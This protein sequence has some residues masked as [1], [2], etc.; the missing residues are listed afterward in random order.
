M[1]SRVITGGET[2]TYAVAE[3][4]TGDTLSALNSAKLEAQS[5]GAAAIS[6]SDL[7]SGL[8]GQENS[9]AERV[10]C[11][12]ANAFYLRWL[13]GLP[14]LP[15]EQAAA[16]DIQPDWHLA[17]PPEMQP[18]A[19]R[20][21]AFAV[22]EADHD[23][24]YWIDSDHLLRGLLSFPN[25]ADFALLKTELS[26][27]VA[28]ERSRRDREDFLPDQNPNLKVVE[29]LVRK[30]FSLW[31]SPILSVACYLYILMQTIGIGV[32]PHAR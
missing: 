24:E 26:L 2:V 21:L 8:I 11:L 15:R 29:Y 7:L 9:R 17:T 30:H 10:G 19:K 4:Y 3:R 22:F 23:R 6:V 12:K 31:I 28:R 32:F 1:A 13:T 20:A 5:R 27:N 18:E 14:A 16:R 25:Q